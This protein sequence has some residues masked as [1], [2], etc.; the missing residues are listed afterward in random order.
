[1]HLE[2]ANWNR[3]RL[4][5]VEI[6]FVSSPQPRRC[7]IYFLCTLQFY[8]YIYI[9]VYYYIVIYLM[10]YIYIYH[11]I[12]NLYSIPIHLSPILA[13]NLAGGVRLFGCLSSLVSL[14]LSPSMPSAAR[15]YGDASLWLPLWLVVSGS[16]DVF[17][18]LSLLSHHLSLA[19]LPIYLSP[20]YFVSN[21]RSALVVVSGSF[22]II[23]LPRSVSYLI[24]LQ[25]H[26]S[27]IICLP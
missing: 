13:S 3:T 14:H 2:K 20:N 7:S 5:E 21:H 24:C 26:L 1:M 12:Y 16:L 11:C 10:I 8:T 27:P 9:Y 4:L 6:G 19:I 22:A 23:F 25:S 18:L 15:L 17:S